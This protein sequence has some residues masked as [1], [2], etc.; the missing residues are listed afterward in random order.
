V[1]TAAPP[2]GRTNLSKTP[3]PKSTP[4]AQ[5]GGVHRILGIFDQRRLFR[6]SAFRLALIYATL[7]SALSAATLGFIY[8]STRDQIESQVDARLRLET[9]YLINLYESRAMAEVLEH[10][11]QR[12]QNDSYGRFYELSNRET[13]ASNADQSEQDLPIRLKSIRSLRAIWA[14]WLSW[15]QAVHVPS[16]RFVFRK[17]SYPMA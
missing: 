15:L 11:Q 9:D 17:H 7:F 12:N 3:G 5:P 4:P 8:W 14:M 13:I 10:I 6:T 16:N 2:L 1:N